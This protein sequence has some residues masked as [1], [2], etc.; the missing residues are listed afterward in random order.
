M[1]GRAKL[2]TPVETLREA[3]QL[4]EVPDLPARYNIAPTQPIP[5][6]RSPHRLDLLR[7]GLMIANAKGRGGGINVRV[8]SVA[9]APAYRD[10]FRARRCLVVVDGFYEW[11]KN[12]TGRSQPYIVQRQ[13]RRPF[14]LA[15]IWDRGVTLDGEV[16]ESCAVLTG[17]ARGVV[18]Q[19]HDR[20]P[21]IV[22]ASEYARWIDGDAKEV[23]D[24]LVPSADGLVAYAVSTIVNSP[25]IDDSRC[26][27]AVA[28]SETAPRNLTLFD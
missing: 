26:V 4:D 11:K 9:R 7:W 17:P 15:G 1:C 2:S 28:E 20:M 23:A 19:V 8:E 16:L 22:P 3:F 24:L 27:E 13:D 5:V 21:I 18:A 6:V 12:A 10:A 25:T 14:A